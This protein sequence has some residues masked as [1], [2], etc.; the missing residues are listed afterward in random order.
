MKLIGL[1]GAAQAGKN[2]FAEEFH[3]HSF[4]EYSFADPLK[5]ACSA[6]FEIPLHNFL[7]TKMKEETDS[8]WKVTPREILQFVG[9]DLVRANMEK[10]LPKVGNDFLVDVMKY[11][12][13]LAQL[14][15]NSTGNEARII[16][17]DCR[18]TNEVDFIL[19]LGG[20]I[21]YLTRPEKDGTVGIPEHTSE[22]LAQEFPTLYPESDYI[23]Y[24][25]NEGTVT[26][27][28]LKAHTFCSDFAPASTV[29]PF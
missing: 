5:K 22:V 28:K 10:L 17:T 11:K 25:S 27:L 6:M 26:D 1:V 23:H 16:V 18:F 24:F 2:T 15:E 12:L 8:Y 14:E 9:T 29:S 20:H 21:C 19:Q 13:Y 3:Y 4:I 7:D